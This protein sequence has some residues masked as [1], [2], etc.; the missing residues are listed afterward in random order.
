MNA[1]IQGEL[2]RFFK[3][4]PI[5]AKMSSN[6]NKISGD[7]NGESM[8]KRGKHILARWVM[9]ENGQI[10]P[11][12]THFNVSNYVDDNEHHSIA[13][14]EQ[15]PSIK[16]EDQSNNSDEALNEIDYWKE[17]SESTS[18]NSVDTSSSINILVKQEGH[19]MED[20]KI[21]IETV[22]IAHEATSSHSTFAVESHTTVASISSSGM[23]DEID[24]VS[25]A[26][27][28]ASSNL[29]TPDVTKRKPA[30]VKSTES[31]KLASARKK[32]SVGIS[33][34][35]TFSS[36]KVQTVT[37]STSNSTQQPVIINSSNAFWAPHDTSSSDIPV[38]KRNPS[39]TLFN[40]QNYGSSNLLSNGSP[41]ILKSNMTNLVDVN[42]PINLP[43]K[44][45]YTSVDK[46]RR[47][48]TTITH[49]QPAHSQSLQNH[50][51]QQQYQPYPSDPSSSQLRNIEAH[52]NN[53]M[54]M[55][56]MTAVPNTSITSFM[57]QNGAIG[58]HQSHQGKM[59]GNSYSSY[60][61]AFQSSSA[62]N[63]F[64]MNPNLVNGQ[65][66]GFAYCYPV[67]SNNHAGQN[68]LSPQLSVNPS[69]VMRNMPSSSPHA[70]LIP[71][72]MTSY[73]PYDGQHRQYVNNASFLSLYPN[74]QYAGQT[75]LGQTSSINQNNMF[76]TT[77]SPPTISSTI[78][79]PMS[80]NRE[81]ANI[82]D[83]QNGSRATFRLGSGGSLRKNA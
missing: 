54:H 51:Q 55:T 74:N 50:M 45:T 35:S 64:R 31:K 23:V 14:L 40:N 83:S 4:K 8:E 3:V 2:V 20:I 36:Q 57:N 18:S 39:S 13:Y 17:S 19:L 33:T 75:S 60:A 82:A 43:L 42:T 22:D 52:A 44:N 76:V 32:N 71:G 26:T 21:P 72:P 66:F 53:W 70:F 59:D 15:L 12:G 79:P 9:A 62:M 24:F 38:S 11:L 49:M 7:A 16:L 29:A 73:I 1:T 63:Y 56:P 68:N 37:V 6:G 27:A 78:M 41:M 34:D 61:P 46:T 47:N 5:P 28:V 30:R 80:S 10:A 69:N 65:N 81:V 77:P 67:N 58:Q 48:F 25:K